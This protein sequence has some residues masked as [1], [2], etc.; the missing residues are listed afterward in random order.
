[1]VRTYR[2]QAYRRPRKG[3]WETVTAPIKQKDLC[4]IKRSVSKTYRGKKLRVIT[5]RRRKPKG[6]WSWGA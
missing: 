2:I 6:F 4:S 1:M 5:S 3:K